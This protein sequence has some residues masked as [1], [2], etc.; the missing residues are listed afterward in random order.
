MYSIPLFGTVLSL[1]KQPRMPPPFKLAF[2]NES[3]SK[4]PKEPFFHIDP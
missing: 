4:Y 2:F 1:N 3:I